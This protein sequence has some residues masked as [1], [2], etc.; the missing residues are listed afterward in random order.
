MDRKIRGGGI[1]DQYGL[2][3]RKRAQLLS[4]LK[5]SCR[6]L[7]DQHTQAQPDH[8]PK[9]NETQGPQKTQRRPD[10]RITDR[11][12][13]DLHFSSVCLSFIHAPVEKW[14]TG[15]KQ[16]WRRDTE[17]QHKSLI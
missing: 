5:G 7:E 12:D 10:S 3:T 8:R 11:K 17:C 1:F 2:K 15:P 14:G 6:G 9:H 16:D 4:T 13:F